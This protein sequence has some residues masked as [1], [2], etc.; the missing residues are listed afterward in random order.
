MIA[1]AACGRVD[2]GPRD[3]GDASL[4]PIARPCGGGTAAPD[5]VTIQGMTYRYTGFNDQRQRIANVTVT[6][7]DE[8]GAA[9]AE[10]TSDPSGAY[11]L[12]LP[13]E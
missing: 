1:L 10:T 12:S 11:R 6:A 13:T 3:A 8:L 2:F 7:F 5:P 4:S 9:L